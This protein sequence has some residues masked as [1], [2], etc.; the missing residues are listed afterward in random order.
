[1]NEM[2][3]F[4]A[5]G[6]LD[7]ELLLD[8]EQFLAAPA[9]RRSRSWVKWGGLAA[10][11]AVA[12]CAVWVLAPKEPGQMQQDAALPEI[13]QGAPH[14]DRPAVDLEEASQAIVPMH[15]NELSGAPEQ[16]TA[17]LFALMWEDFEPMTR[18]ELL[19][20][21]GVSL[22]VEEV[23]PIFSAAGP[24]EGDNLGRGIYRSESRGVY[25]DANTFSFETADGVVGVYVTLGKAFHPPASL[26]ELPGDSLNFT[27]INGWELALFCYPD[28]EGNQYF[29]TEFLQDGVGY[30]VCGK[31]M[32]EQEYAAVLGALLEERSD[33]APG[34]TRTFQGTYSGGISHQTLTTTN[35]DGSVTIE[36]SWLGPLS[37]DLDG[38]SEYRCLWIELTPEQAEKFSDL[39]PGGRV[40]VSF[41][42]EPASIGT[43][44]TQQLTRVEKLEG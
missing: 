4:E 11:A 34:E 12:V 17:A 32:C 43:V 44:W 42:G 26:W 31:N 29:Y 3:L 15:F 28:E 8:A 23:M 33:Y 27:V 14:A 18:E 30:Q 1:M 37:L 7:D 6:E 35:P 13:T 10:C 5:V 36:E 9:A 19:E 22:P 24:E 38:G 21:F 39:S 16:S 40:E 25:F 2:R 41:T 20:Y